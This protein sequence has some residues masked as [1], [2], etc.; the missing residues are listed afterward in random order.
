[1][2]KI[3]YLVHSAVNNQ[4]HKIIRFGIFKNRAHSYFNNQMYLSSMSILVAIFDMML[5]AG[6][7]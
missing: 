7:V 4:N 6:N 2:Y 5:E 1:M 3:D